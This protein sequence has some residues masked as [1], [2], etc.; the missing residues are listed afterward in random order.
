MNIRQD[1]LDYSDLVNNS[2]N[3]NNKFQVILQGKN[4]LF[5]KINDSGEIMKEKKHLI[6]KAS[7]TIKQPAE[8]NAFLY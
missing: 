7:K 4:N 8:L 3:K 2:N 6:N 5:S 1:E